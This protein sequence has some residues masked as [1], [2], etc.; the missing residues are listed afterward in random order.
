MSRLDIFTIVIVVVCVGAILFLLYKTTNIFGSKLDNQEIVTDTG[1]GEENDILDPADYEEYYDDPAGEGGAASDV[2][3]G[4]P[5][6]SEST[7]VYDDEAT[8]GG[9]E[10]IDYATDDAGS[11]EAET[12]AGGDT[13]QSDTD[14][15]NDKGSASDGDYLVLAG[16]FEF[17]HNADSYAKN[18]RNLGYTNAEVV[19]FNRGK[20]ATVMVDRFFSSDQA[21]DLL[22]R[23]EKDGV[24]AYL[25]KKRLAN[26]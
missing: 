2:E 18:L 17:R 21:M 20:Y 24:D 10:G 7:I 26:N 5:S 3:D 13:Y 19:M 9:E 1:E 16:S 11:S 15:T 12:S 4:V 22:N 25:H 6:G 23:L 14:F 8:A